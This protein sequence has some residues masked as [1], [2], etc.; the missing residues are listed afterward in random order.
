M[1]AVTSIP[2]LL[3]LKCTNCGSQ[4]APTDISPHLA[5]ARCSHCHALFALPTTTV[6]NSS[7][8]KPEVALPKKLTFVDFGDGVEITR[9]WFGPAAFVLL[10][11][12]LFWNGFMIIWN[13]ISIAKGMWT[14][15]IFGL[16][17]TAVGLGLIYLVLSMF[18]NVTTVRVWMGR[19][20]VKIGPIPWKGNKDLAAADV[21][22]LY[23]KEKVTH[24]K[25][26]STTKYQVEVITRGN[27]SETLVA[28]LETYEQ[29]LFIEQQIERKL[30]IADA[31]VAGEYGV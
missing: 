23:C 22:Q 28:D 19:L 16:L 15:G 5:A 21:V 30:K 14:M 24:G 17:H 12:A 20:T 29:A 1:A 13:G 27:L 9:K 10:P 31:K 4:L 7:L 11:F 25:N 18:L 26:G 8:S 2:S 3:E 6:M